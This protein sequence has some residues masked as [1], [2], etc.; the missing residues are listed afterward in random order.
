[1]RDFQVLLIGLLTVI[2]CELGMVAVRLP[3]SPA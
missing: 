1:M 2:A 3:A